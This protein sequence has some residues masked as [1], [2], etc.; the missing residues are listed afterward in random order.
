MPFLFVVVALA[1]LAVVA[2]VAAG[3][4]DTLAEP[5]PDVPPPGLPPGRLGSADLVGVRFP[6]VF[7]GYRMDQVDEVLDRLQRELE[8]RDARIAELEDSRGGV[9][10]GG[11]G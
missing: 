8:E 4:G 6:V 10:R 5:V 11:R 7:R 9:E 1:V 3:R 2:V